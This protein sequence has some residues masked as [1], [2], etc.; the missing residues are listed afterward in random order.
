MT[1]GGLMGRQV[2]SRK[3]LRHWVE[4]KMKVSPLFLRINSISLK[5]ALDTTTAYCNCSSA[6][7]KHRWPHVSI[8]TF[9]YSYVNVNPLEIFFYVQVW[10][11]V[12]A[13]CSCPLCLMPKSGVGG[14]DT[15]ALCCQKPD[16]SVPP[17]GCCN[18]LGS[19]NELDLSR[20]VRQNKAELRR[21]VPRWGPRSTHMIK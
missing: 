1:H 5:A 18:W 16:E 6:G 12:C 9:M 8:H 15:G 7:E 11:W 10:V 14:E 2:V 13:K 19:D 17:R 21:W 20:S 3:D 4:Q